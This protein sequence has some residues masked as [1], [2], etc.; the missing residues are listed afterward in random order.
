MQEVTEIQVVGEMNQPIVYANFAKVQL[1]PY[2]GMITFARI[3]PA[4]AFA[5]SGAEMADTV[6]A[7]AVAR[8]ALPHSVMQGLHK[9]LGEQLSKLSELSEGNSPAGGD[10]P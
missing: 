7:P 6:D 2:E 4:T 9:A 3:D 8:L 5:E 1:T 10:E